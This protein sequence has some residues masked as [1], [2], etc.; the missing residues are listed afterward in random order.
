MLEDG[1]DF[2]NTVI[3]IEPPAF[4]EDT[5]EGSGDEEWVGTFSNLNR[6]QLQAPATVTVWRDGAKQLF[7][8]E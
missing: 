4:H 5:D 3:F 1:L 6:S 2:E 8:E 7:E